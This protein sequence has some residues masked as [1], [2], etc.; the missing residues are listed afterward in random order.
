MATV[1]D[2]NPKAFQELNA[3]LKA[4]DSKVVKVGWF[5]SAQYE[6]G[7]P[8]AYVAS[9]AELG[10]GAT[11]PRS[12][13]RTTALAKVSDWF[14]IAARGANAVLE[15]N[16]T[17]DDVLG[18]LGVKIQEDIK[19]TIA[20][21]YSPPLSKVTLMARKYREEGRKVAGKQIGR[22]V[23]KVKENDYKDSD[24]STNT[25]PLIETKTMIRTLTNVVEEA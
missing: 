13:M 3:G 23:R 10:H 9:L 2:K 5:E 12:F 15:G 18:A 19:D 14:D 4:L 20:N 8:V 6:N 17:V 24:L 11:P 21:L 16:E 7:T 25:K 22:F 1:T